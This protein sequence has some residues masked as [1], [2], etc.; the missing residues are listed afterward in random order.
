MKA[1]FALSDDSDC[2]ETVATAKEYAAAKI[3]YY[4]AARQAVPVLLQIAIIANRK[5]DKTDIT[6]GDEL[7]EIFRGFSGDRD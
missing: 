4:M 7:T 1:A 5:G 6:L 2:S 3:A